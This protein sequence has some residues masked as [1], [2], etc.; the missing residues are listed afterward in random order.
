MRG[1]FTS[2]IVINLIPMEAVK[3]N[4]FT[5]HIAQSDIGLHGDNCWCMNELQVEANLSLILMQNNNNL[6]FNV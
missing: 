1:I 3:A 2:S 4:K 6:I 5:G